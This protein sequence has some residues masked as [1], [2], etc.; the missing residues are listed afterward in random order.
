MS[1][2]NLNGLEELFDYKNKLAEDVLTNEAIVALLSDDC[3]ATA[4]PECL[5]YNQV[6]PYEFVPETVEHG[7]TF[8]CFEVDIRGV[9]NKTFL[10][11]SIYVWIFTHK[12][13][14]RLPSG[15]V[16][17]D[18]LASEIVSV[19]NGSRYYGLGELNLYSVKRFSPGTDYYGRLITFNTKDFNRIYPNGKESPINRKGV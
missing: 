4:H 18:K 19:L 15:G 10:S 11:P 6:F 17:I 9:D 3:I 8:I 13:K 12:S 5:M 2:N 1:G 7:Q 14:M 16:R